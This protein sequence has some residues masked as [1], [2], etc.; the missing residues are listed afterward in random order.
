[1][2][3]TLAAALGSPLVEFARAVQIPTLDVKPPNRVEIARRVVLVPDSLG[4]RE[5]LVED[6]ERAVVGPMTCE[7]DPCHKHAFKRGKDVVGTTEPDTLVVE[8]GRPCIVTF[9]AFE[10]GAIDK[11]R[12]LIDDIGGLTTE[13]EGAIEFCAG[14]IETPGHLVNE[15]LVQEASGQDGWGIDRLGDRGRLTRIIETLIKVV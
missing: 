5:P 7:I 11:C 14:G 8:F 6:G 3:A 13:G 2:I 9:P 10:F 1:M 12:R 4:E 15:R